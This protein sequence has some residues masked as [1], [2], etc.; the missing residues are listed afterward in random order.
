MDLG[1]AE[2]VVLVTGAS[3]GIGR[4]AALAFGRERARVAVTYRAEQ[5]RAASLVS[6]LQSMGTDAM[7]APLDLSDA[8]TIR[9]AVQSVLARWGRVDVLINN[10][11]DWGERTPDQAPAFEDDDPALWRRML[12]ANVD[13]H[14]AAIRAVLPSMRAQRWGRIVNVSSTIAADGLAGSGAYGAAKGALHGLTRTLARELGPLGILTNVVMP[15]LTLTETN[16]ERLPPALVEEYGQHAATGRL[17]SPE[18]VVPV[19]VFLASA[20]NTAVI[21]EIVRASGG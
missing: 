9:A 18:E 3:R 12:Q 1:L 13:G 4:A 19:I 6:E 2:K 15:G 16:R 5:A 8:G 21:G 14:A 17:L 10:A 11:V 20:A 7:A